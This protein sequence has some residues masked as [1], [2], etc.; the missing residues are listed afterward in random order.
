MR[1]SLL[2]Q[3]PL[4]FFTVY[5]AMVSNAFYL[6]FVDLSDVN[7]VGKASESQ[8]YV[9]IWLTLYAV[10]IGAIA[11][12]KPLTIPKTW[13]FGGILTLTSVVAY[14]TNGVEISS[15]VKLV[16]LVLTILFGGWA[17]D[18]FSSDRVLSI[19]F[20][21]AVVLT[22]VHLLLYPLLANAEFAVVYDRLQRNTLLGTTPYAGIFPHKNLAATFFVQAIVIGVGMALS[23]GGKW[24]AALFVRLGIFMVALLLSGAVSP[25][26]S[27]ALSI[28][29]MF[30]GVTYRR[31]P[32]IAGLVGVVVVAVIAALVAFPDTWLELFNRDDTFTGR[33]YLYESWYSHFSAQPIFGYGYG[34]AFS[35]TD[36]SLGEALNAGTGLWYS[37]YQNFESGFLQALIEF[38]LIGGAT[39]AAVFYFAGR[40]AVRALIDGSV[41]YAVAPL[42]VFTYCL[43]SSLNE[44]PVVVPNTTTLFLLSFLYAK[45]F[46]RSSA[47]AVTGL[48]PRR[49]RPNGRHMA[50]VGSR[51]R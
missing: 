3:F 33:T 50:L 28:A 29:V 40:Y 32:A 34:E 49:S 14:V 8:A 11:L 24:S 36:N 22:V 21:L 13:I 30:V 45:L 4:A 19:F 1:R 41:S 44:V 9:A 51:L 18:R 17:A 12:I 47:E 48:P 7:N 20:S 46:L 23:P 38:G 10:L 27:G 31:A 37:R 26:L 16:S 42:G 35:G 39:Y 2:S 15:I 43:V 25:I 6:V 5:L